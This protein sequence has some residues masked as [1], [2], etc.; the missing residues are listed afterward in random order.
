MYFKLQ[1]WAFLK[2]PVEQISTLLYEE[3]IVTF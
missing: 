3:Y 1:V 2:L